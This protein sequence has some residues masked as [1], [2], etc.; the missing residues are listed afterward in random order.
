M[1]ASKQKKMYVL[2]TKALQFNYFE[3]VALAL[4]KHTG[5]LN[6]CRLCTA[7][8]ICFFH[9]V[10]LWLSVHWAALLFICLWT[11]VHG[12]FHTLKKNG[13]KKRE[14]KGRR[15]VSP[16]PFKETVAPFAVPWT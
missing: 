13:N 3:N 2:P 6:I 7:F 15:R 14:R 16:S 12:T 8:Y 4:T 10:K 1:A 9:C 11:F 5:S